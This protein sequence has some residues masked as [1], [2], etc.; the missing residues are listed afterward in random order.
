LESTTKRYIFHSTEE[1]KAREG[2]RKKIKRAWGFWP[3]WEKR[4]EA[5]IYWEQKPKKGGK[6]QIRKVSR[7]GK[8]SGRRRRVLA[9]E[10]EVSCHEGKTDGCS[11]LNDG[12]G[13]PGKKNA[14]KKEKNGKKKKTRKN[15]GKTVAEKRKYQRNACAGQHE[16][17][18][19]H[20]SGGQKKN[21][22][23]SATVGEK[24]S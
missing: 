4:K 11:P 15:K 10:T 21:T 7:G 9:N 14:A 6:E 8:K 24:T 22:K 20:L 5:K 16:G 23:R 18:F 19:K 1:E 3:T 2:T 13:G 12:R 17:R